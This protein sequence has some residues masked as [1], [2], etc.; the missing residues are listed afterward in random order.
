MAATAHLYQ[1]FIRAT[2]DEV[3]QAI[4]DPTWTARY[5][6]GTAFHSSLQPGSPMGYTL[7]DRTVVTGTVEVAEPPHRLV[8]T[9]QFVDN[10]ALAEEP[11]SRVEWLIEPAGDGLTRVRVAHRDLARSPQTWAMV[12]DG[13]AWI[14]DAMKSLI[15]T[16]EPLPDWAERSAASAGD[17]DVEG[18]WHRAQAITA[19]NSTWDMITAERTPDNDEEMLRRAYAA[20]YHWARAAGRAPANEVRAR[21]LLAKAHL[22]AG[23]AHAAARYADSC[24]DGC[25]EHG[26]ADFDLA[27]ALEMQARSALALGETARGHALWAQAKA[28]PI[29]DP[30]D[31]AIVDCDFAD[32]P[33]G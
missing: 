1:I 19:N 13:W 3:W 4:T 9:W 10:P 12:K 7:D 16:G 15:E 21:Y 14:L 24:H 2:P 23:D 22:L 32:A 30:E 17:D 11:P 8:T 27:Y 6:H 25:V 5:F 28:V 29:A 18:E 20:A 33:A 31:Q 26:L